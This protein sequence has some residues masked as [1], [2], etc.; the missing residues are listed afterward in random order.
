VAPPRR[1]P[2]PLARR[3][4]STP[5]ALRA[6]G[7][8]CLGRR[9]EL[10]LGVEQLAGRMGVDARQVRRIERGQANVTFETLV[11]L[12]TGLERLPSDLL[13]QVERALILE[14]GAAA[15]TKG[16]AQAAHAEPAMVGHG[17]PSDEPL[18]RALGLAVAAFRRHGRLT[19]RELAS[20]AG[21][22]LSAIQSVESGRHAPTTLTLETL[23]LALKCDVLDL[24]TAR[25]AKSAH[26]AR[27]SRTREA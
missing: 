18:H 4:F 26:K 22:S 2:E 17:V 20:A 9:R 13:A 14:D 8:V 5:V 7:E 19:Q 16:R 27:V 11:A 23:A 12:A 10:D 1:P 24:F 15:A 21:L 3:P 6:L 25:A